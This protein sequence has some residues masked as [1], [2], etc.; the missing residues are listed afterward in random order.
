MPSCFPI[1]IVGG[2]DFEIEEQEEE[3]N[4]ALTLSVYFVK[5]RF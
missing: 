3:K 1:R 4:D 2:I 5:R